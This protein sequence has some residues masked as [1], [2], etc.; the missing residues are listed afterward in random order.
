M[1]EIVVFRKIARE[2]FCTSRWCQIHGM[3]F[4][5][6]LLKLLGIFKNRENNTCPHFVSWDRN[7]LPE[8]CISALYTKDYTDKKGIGYGWGVLE[9]ALD[10]EGLSSGS[11]ALAV[12]LEAGIFFFLWLGFLVHKIRIDMVAF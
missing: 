10:L 9:R 6:V 12:D 7:N 2:E 11:A 1:G 3:L 8:E 5:L 4:Y